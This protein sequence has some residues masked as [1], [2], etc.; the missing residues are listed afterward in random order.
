MPRGAGGGRSYRSSSRAAAPSVSIIE[1]DA[2]VSVDAHGLRASIHPIDVARVRDPRSVPTDTSPSAHTGSSFYDSPVSG[3]PQTDSPP[4]TPGDE[5]AGRK[6]LEVHQHT[7]HPEEEDS[8]FAAPASAGARVENGTDEKESARG[9][10]SPDKSTA[11]LSSSAASTSP[12]T[13]NV[14]QRRLLLQVS[15][16]TT[17]TSQLRLANPATFRIRT[18]GATAPA[19][20]GE[21]A[22]ESPNDG[23]LSLEVSEC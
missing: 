5:A 18:N 4:R 14:I 17:T 13:P 8:P 15:N 1:A 3:S 16:S 20:V 19:A 9:D 11:S 21:A 6:V 2:S 12:A 7:F 22:P 10:S 23:P